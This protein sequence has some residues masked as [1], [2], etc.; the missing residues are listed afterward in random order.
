MF[1]LEDRMISEQHNVMPLENI[2][3]SEK[4]DGSPGV[5]MKAPIAVGK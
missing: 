4:P 3:E 2:D 1:I 5:E